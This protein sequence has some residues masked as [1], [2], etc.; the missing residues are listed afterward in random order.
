MTASGNQQGLVV[1]SSPDAPEID[2][3]KGLPHELPILA[4]GRTPDDIGAEFY[5]LKT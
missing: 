3:L 1:I 4:I 2:A 5:Q